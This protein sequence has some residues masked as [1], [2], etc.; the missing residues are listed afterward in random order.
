MYEILAQ[1]L[2]SYVCSF[3]LAYLILPF[4]V[5]TWSLCVCVCGVSLSVCTEHQN[6]DISSGK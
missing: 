5:S 4:P 1:P 3:R 6:E 2:D